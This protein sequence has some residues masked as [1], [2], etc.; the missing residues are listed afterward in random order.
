MGLGQRIRSLFRLFVLFTVLLAVALISAITT[1]RL[2][3]HSGQETIPNFAGMKLGE[4]ERRAGFLGLGVKVEDHMYSDKYAAEEIVSQIPAAGTSVKSGQ[5][6][7]VL[8]SLGPPRVAVPDLT[9]SSARAAEITAV[10][11]GLTL[12]DV[13][14]IHGNGTEVDQVVSQEPAPAATELRS[15]SVNLLVSAGEAPVSYVCPNF[16]GLRV[17]EARRAISNAG[18]KVGEVK[19]ATPAPLPGATTPPSGVPV[20]PSVIVAQTPPAGSKITRDTVFD[21]QVSP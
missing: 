20:P 3:I 21:F 9:G 8:V 13:V 2:T 7:H 10:Q 1:I 5:D 15:P 17:S 18:F 12:G 14:T 16:V 11:H 19:T 6:V 4:A